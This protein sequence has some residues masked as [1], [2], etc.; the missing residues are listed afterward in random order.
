MFEYTFRGNTGERGRAGDGGLIF[1][2]LFSGVW[3]KLVVAR[4][5]LLKERI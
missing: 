1:F 2:P 3:G 4:G 5:Q